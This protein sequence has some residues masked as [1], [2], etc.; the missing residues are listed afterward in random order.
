MGK[1]TFFTGQPVYTANNLYGE[2][3]CQLHEYEHADD[4]ER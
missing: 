3:A 1:N 2:H 4:E